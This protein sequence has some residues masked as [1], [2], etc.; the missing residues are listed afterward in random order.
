MKAELRRIGNGNSNGLL[1]REQQ[2]GLIG[3][4]WFLDRIA[5]PKLGPRAAIEAW[6]GQEGSPKDFWFDKGCLEVKTS[7]AGAEKIEISSIEHN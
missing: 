6:H 3:E 4:L 7:G 2:R 1:T 5:I